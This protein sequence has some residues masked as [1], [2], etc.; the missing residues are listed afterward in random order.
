M[1]DGQLR[2]MYKLTIKSTAYSYLVES[3][4]DSVSVRDTSIVILKD[5]TIPTP[6]TFTGVENVIEVVGDESLKT[7]DSAKSVISEFVKFGVDRQTKIV[8]IGGGSVQDI[9]TFVCSIYMRGI[10]W[11][12]IPTTL[13]AMSDSCI[14]GKS[15]LNLGEVKNVLGNYYPPSK[16]IIDVAY[17]KTLGKQSIVCGLFEAIK[18]NYAANHENIS[19]FSELALSWIYKDEESNLL[20]LIFTTLEKKKWFIEVDEFDKKERKLLN[21]GH[22]FGHALESA[23]GMSIPHGLAIGIGM[24]C[25]M[26]YAGYIDTDLSNF[27]SEMLSWCEFSTKELNFSSQKFAEAL[28]KDKK[29]SLGKQRLVLPNSSG[30]LYLSEIEL[31]P[32]FLENQCCIMIS[33][34]ERYK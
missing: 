25:A 12:Y 3:T 22:S 8:A 4:Y 7:L 24:Q 9:A 10:D 23:S 1:G 33:I 30:E 14:G 16:I 27:I 26:E 28:S 5:S 18:I 19:S 6:K 21:F 32:D 29:N 11:I 2:A 13:M 17:I 31:N 20:S 15:S 34:L